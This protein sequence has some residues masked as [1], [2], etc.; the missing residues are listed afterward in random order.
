MQVTPGD[1]SFIA[2]GFWNPEPS[3]LKLIR[4]NIDFD[5]QNFRKIINTPSLIKVW[6]TVQGDQVKTSPKGY[7]KDHPAIDL[8]KHKQFIF[9]KAYSDK[10]VTSPKFL[11]SISKSFHAIRPFFDYMS[12][13]L[14]HDMNGEPLY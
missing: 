2:V 11:A 12:N 9:T 7:S 1:Q 10:D 5:H 6:K 14:T 3:D 13:I 4:Q 8:L